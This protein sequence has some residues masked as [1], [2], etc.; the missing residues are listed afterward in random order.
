[1]SET[2]G[3]LSPLLVNFV[4]VYATRRVEANQN[5]LKLNCTYQL[6]VYADDVNILGGN[7][8]TIKEKYRS[9]GNG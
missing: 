8:H 4:L 7:I 6:L 2:G 9:F 5:G 3:T 1:L